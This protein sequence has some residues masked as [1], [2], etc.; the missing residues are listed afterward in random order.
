VRELLGDLMGAG[1]T[2]AGVSKD[3]CYV[4]SREAGR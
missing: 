1:W 3:G 2:V 4:V